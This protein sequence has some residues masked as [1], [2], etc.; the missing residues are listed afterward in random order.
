MLRDDYEKLKKI[1]KDSDR[2]ALL[3]P[4]ESYNDHR[5]VIN[6]RDKKTAMI[7]SYQKNY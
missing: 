4:M 2:Y 6:L 7:K 5:I 1:W 3:Y